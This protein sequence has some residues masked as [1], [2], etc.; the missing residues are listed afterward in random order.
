MPEVC[1]SLA[2]CS[3]FATRHCSLSLIADC[4]FLRPATRLPSL[5]RASR[6]AILAKGHSLAR[7]SFSGGGPL[8][9]IIP[10]PLATA[11]LRVVPAS[12]VTTTSRTHVGAPTFSPQERTASEGGPYTSFEPS[13]FNFEPLFSPKSNYSRTYEPLSRKSNDSRTYAK[14]WGW[15]SSNQMCSPLTLLFSS[16]MLIN[17]LRANVGA[18][19]FWSAGREEAQALRGS[20]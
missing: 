5:P 17:Q 12:I 3:P 11:A 8:I 1:F 15:G 4:R 13:T 6:G 20:G 14:T 16:A 18:P 9:P 2:S 19:T 7:R 10:A